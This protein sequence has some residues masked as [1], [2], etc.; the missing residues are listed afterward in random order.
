MRYCQIMQHRLGKPLNR[1]TVWR[2][3]K[4]LDQIHCPTSNRGRRWVSEDDDQSFLGFTGAVITLVLEKGYCDFS[5]LFPVVDKSGDPRHYHPA[6]DD[7]LARLRK[8]AYPPAMMAVAVCELIPLNYATRGGRGS[9]SKNETECE[10]LKNIRDQR[11][12]LER[13]K[14]QLIK[15]GYS[16]TDADQA[17]SDVI[18]MSPDE[19]L[20]ILK[21]LLPQQ[22]L[23]LGEPLGDSCAGTPAHRIDYCRGASISRAMASYWRNH[24]QY[25]KCK[26]WL[27]GLLPTI[28]PTHPHWERVVYV[29][30]LL[31]ASIDE[32]LKRLRLSTNRPKLKYS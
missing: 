13:I 24:K 16:G 3:D 23:E 11:T 29:P 17:A 19:R 18:T 32:C 6:K 2:R 1:S 30:K 31:N 20:A 9:A 14:A 21:E 26:A 22:A 8:S 4:R 25:R 12:L 5:E 27:R 10:A 28:I 15:E 7:V